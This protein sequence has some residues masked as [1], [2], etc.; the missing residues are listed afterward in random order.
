MIWAVYTAMLLLAGAIILL[1]LYRAEDTAEENE[2]SESQENEALAVYRQQL[3]E[4]ERDISTGL[5]NEDEAEEA[6]LEIHRRMLAASK[7]ISGGGAAGLSEKIVAGVVI[8]VMAGVTALYASRGEPGLVS[9]PPDRGASAAQ[10]FELPPA[11]GKIEDRLAQLETRLAAEPDNLEGWTM[12]G[13]SYRVLG[14]T[15]AAAEAYGR[16]AALDPENVELRLIQTELLVEVLDGLISPAAR[17]VLAKIEEI[18]PGHP[19]PG[20][21]LGLAEYQNNNTR[22]ALEI[23]TALE[24]KSPAEAP[25][26]AALRARIEGAQADLGIGE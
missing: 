1:P 7:E 4:L 9:L 23:W 17:L 19:A 5:L 11:M 13:R 16:A 25:W 10:R 2:E 18:D 12:L 15:S 21:Y 22:M 20:F 24:A 6:R 14:R 26:L 8:L 3:V